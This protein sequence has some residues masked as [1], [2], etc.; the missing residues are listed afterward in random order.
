MLVATAIMGTAQ[1]VLGGQP[2]LIVGV[3]EP[4]VLI[5][6]FMFS[7][8]KGAACM[9]RVSSACHARAHTHRDRTVVQCRPG[10]AGSGLVPAMGGLGLH[11]DSRHD[12]PA[13]GRRHLP[14]G[15]QVHAAERR[16]L[17]LPHCGALHAAGHQ[18]HSQRVPAMGRPAG[19]QVRS[20][21]PFRQVHYLGEGA[22]RGCMLMCSGPGTEYAWRLV[23]GLWALFLACGLTL[24]ALLLR[25]AHRWRF[26][27]ALMRQL[28][29]DYG[30]PLMVLVWSALSYAL[31]GAPPGV[32]RRVD[33]PNTWQDTGP[34]SVARVREPIICALMPTPTCA[35]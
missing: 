30:A 5:Y 14:P 9:R 29:A 20:S 25:T 12:I 11:L 7:F 34:W 17:R 15:V 22:V 2:L 16:A 21:H 27:S 19:R 8:A 10:A 23:N 4:I 1:A 24:T 18:G 31:R 3:A 26:G 6:S 28:V 35:F 32:P 33:V 13:V